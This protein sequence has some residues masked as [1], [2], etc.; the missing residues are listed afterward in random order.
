MDKQIDA[1]F[2]R[3]DK[4]LTTLI[5]SIAKYNPT[6]SQGNDLIAAEAE[7]SKGLEELQTHQQNHATL[8]RLRAKTSKLDGQIKDTL[9]V[10]AK[11]RKE[12]RDTTATIFSEGP[13][14]PINYTELLAYAHRI[15]KTTLPRS[16]ATN[17]NILPPAD[18]GVKPDSGTETAATTPGDTPNG[19]AS[20]SSS[21]NPPNGEPISQQ[22]VTSVTT[23]SLPEQL[24]THLN[25]LANAD[26]IPW[27]TE[28]NIRQGALATLAYLADKG[29]SAEG[30]DPAEEEARR[31]AEEDEARAREE[32]DRLEQEEGERRAREQRERARLE[33]EKNREKDDAEAWRRASVSGAPAPGPSASSPAVKAQFQFMGGDDDDDESD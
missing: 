7:L 2:E 12:L 30:Y 31:R 10:L 5:D 13:N 19:V 8:E 20:T 3:L 23:T 17:G 15:S 29:I 33:R 24:S 26:F 9:V 27:P 4:S 32:R 1:R 11:T 6:I 21:S 14:N 16:I 22:T 18:S 25:P 28:E